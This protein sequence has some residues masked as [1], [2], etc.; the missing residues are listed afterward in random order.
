M[1]KTYS[2]TWNDEVKLILSD[3]DETI[4][5]IYTPARQEMIEELTT[6]LEEKISLFFV[7]GAGLSRIIERITNHIPPKLRKHILISHCNGAEVVGFTQNGILRDEPFY[8]LYDQ[9]MTPQQKQ[10][11]RDI[12]KQLVQEFH[13]KVYPAMPVSSFK[14]QAGND[15]LSVMLEDRGPQITFEMVNA[16]DLSPEQEAALETAVPLTHG[17]LDLRIPVH[18]RADEL[19]KKAKLPITPRLGGVFALDLGLKGVSKTNSIT[20]LLENDHVLASIGLT[21]H[22]LV[23]PSHIEIWGDKFDQYRGGS[24]RHMCE[25][26]NPNV[27]AIDFRKE[28]PEGFLKGYNIVLWDGENQLQDGLLEYL[29]RRHSNII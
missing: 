3:V 7:S 28:N 18:E 29:Q 22:D 14:F 25:A 9:I 1:K 15:P 11:W 2:I 21:K 16:Y 20:H 6:L 27:R 12:V 24:D 8:S 13:L 23:D 5:D 26:V 10:T 4:A 19:L 17:A